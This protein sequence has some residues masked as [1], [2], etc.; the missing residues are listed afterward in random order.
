MNPVKV[1]SRLPEEKLMLRL[2]LTPRTH[3]TGH[4]VRAHLLDNVM[5]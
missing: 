5:Y 2:N 1:G 4:L 3:S